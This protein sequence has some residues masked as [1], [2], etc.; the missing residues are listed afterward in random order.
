MHF[1]DMCEN[2]LFIRNSQENNGELKVEY[3]CKYCGNSKEFDTIEQE[4]NDSSENTVVP[5]YMS[6]DVT[7]PRKKDLKCEKCDIEG[8]AILLRED[9]NKKIYNYYCVDCKQLIALL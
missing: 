4:K 8:T 6:H 3:F 2:M 5:K 9:D 7:L 1:C